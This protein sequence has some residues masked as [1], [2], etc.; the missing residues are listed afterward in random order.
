MDSNVATLSWSL[1]IELGG[2]RQSPVLLIQKNEYLRVYC[3]VEVTAG[4]LAAHVGPAVG[5]GGGE[6]TGVRK[7][8][9]GR[10]RRGVEQTTPSGKRKVSQ[11]CV[12]V[13]VC[14]G[15]EG[16]MKEV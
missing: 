13:C 14:V 8:S 3:R 6:G 1:I 10:A 12:C 9:T 7:E 4:D 15:A 16:D 11:T 5:S 2:G